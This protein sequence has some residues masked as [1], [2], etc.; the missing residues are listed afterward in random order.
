MNI[1][2][3][4]D[5]FHALKMTEQAIIEAVSGA[6]LYL[7]SDPI[8]AIDTAKKIQIDVA[9]LDIHMPEMTG[10]ELAKRLKDINPKI[11]IIFHIP[12]LKTAAATNTS[13]I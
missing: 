3:V 11:N 1:L 5:E 6:M 8:S 9:F 4:D 7:C 13:K 12:G 2:A 10:V